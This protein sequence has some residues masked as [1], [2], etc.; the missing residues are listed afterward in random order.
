MIVKPTRRL[1]VGVQLATEWPLQLPPKRPTSQ[2][3]TI[4]FNVWHVPIT[5]KSNSQEATPSGSHIVP[6]ETKLRTTITLSNCNCL[7]KHKQKLSEVIPDEL[8]A[9]YP[10]IYHIRSIKLIRL[11]DDQQFHIPSLELKCRLI[12]REWDRWEAFNETRNNCC[13][14]AILQMR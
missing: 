8:H 9:S 1:Y 6:S 10:C 11:R 13:G 14:A 4:N 5:G 3:P 7:A 12:V 2:N